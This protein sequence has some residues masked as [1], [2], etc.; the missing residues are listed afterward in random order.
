MASVGADKLMLEFSMTNVIVETI[1]ATII[2]LT[3]MTDGFNRDN[4]FM[5]EIFTDDLKVIY[6]LP[7]ME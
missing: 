4:T 6:N 7:I 5:L 2:A 3:M 1:N